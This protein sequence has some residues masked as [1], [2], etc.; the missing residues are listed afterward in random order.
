MA[1]QQFSATDKNPNDAMG[2]GGCVCDPNKVTDCKGPYIV[3]HATDMYDPLSP[4]PVIC[5]SC[6]HKMAEMLEGEI[7]H[8]DIL[9][10][11]QPIVEHPA[12][13]DAEPNSEDGVKAVRRDSE[14]PETA[15]PEVDWP[16][17]DDDFRDLDI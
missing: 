6:V 10:T 14:D 13:A 3:C 4:Y 16:V 7:A 11:V 5:K 8:I 12:P 17:P 15:A 1:Y 2:G 9:D